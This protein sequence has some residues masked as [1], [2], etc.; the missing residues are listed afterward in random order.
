ML[1]ELVDRTDATVVMSRAA[2]TL[3]RNVYGVDGRR[4][5]IIP[6]GVPDLPLVAPPQVK[7]ISASRAVT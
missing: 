2:G 1:S 4:V 7:P 6:H 3:L 5:H